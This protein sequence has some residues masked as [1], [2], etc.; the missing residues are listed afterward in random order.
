MVERAGQ[1]LLFTHM[2]MRRHRH[3]ERA[4]TDAMLRQ[5]AS[6]RGMVGL[7]PSDDGLT[8]VEVPA[9]L[10]PKGCSKAECAR[11]VSALAAA[12]SEVASV[13][14]A[15]A[16]V[17]GSDYNGGMRHLP[18]SCGTG[19]SLDEEA[20]FFHVGQ[21]KEV[22]QAMR[23]LGAPVP[24]LA[25]TL[26]RFLSTWARVKAVSSGGDASLPPRDEVTGP[27]LALRLGGGMGTALDDP[28]VVL[29]LQAAIHK[30]GPP[31]SDG[32]PTVYFLRSDVDLTQAVSSDDTPFILARVAGL[33]VQAAEHDTLARGEG[34]WLTAA[35]RQ[36]LD[37]SWLLGVSALRGQVRTMPGILKE[38]D[39]F[40]F[41]L[42][43]GIDALGYKHVAHV[44]DR[45]ALDGFHL[46]GGGAHVG[47]SSAFEEGVKLRL[48]GGIDAD[49]NLV[50]VDAETAY[51]SDLDAN[52]GG[53]LLFIAQGVEPFF[54]ASFLANR[55]SHGAGWWL[56]TM[57]YRGGVMFTLF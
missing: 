37:Q 24:P 46:A 51:Q 17:F 6:S 23:K 16:V 36:P 10:C 29:R 11:G 47:F 39:S 5:V 12:Y 52:V 22:W 53:S 28:G 50:F 31:R 55:E 43:L 38:P 49:V 13:V 33:G 2:S 20:G 19:T 9:R 45:P 26:E 30:D 41:W 7:L 35:R 32:E 1:P 54:R 57:R 25:H 3:A 44:S 42:E 27:A 14:G 40:N 21:A 8:H 18:P 34:L 15:D 56:T 4:T 48:G